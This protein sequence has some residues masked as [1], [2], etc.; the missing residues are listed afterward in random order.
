[1]L[2]LATAPT[3]TEQSGDGSTVPVG[4]SNKQNLPI[5]SEF[6]VTGFKVDALAPVLLAFAGL[7]LR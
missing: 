7:R 6:V 4:E 1:M 2:P 3:L 5:S